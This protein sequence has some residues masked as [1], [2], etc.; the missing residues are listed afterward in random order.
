MQDTVPQPEN[1]WPALLSVELV[2]KL[3]GV[4]KRTIHRWNSSQMI[5]RAVGLAGTTRWRRDEIEAWLLAGCPSRERWER[6]AKRNLRN[7]G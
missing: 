3:L 4:S 2:A 6:E 5:P 7:T 1:S